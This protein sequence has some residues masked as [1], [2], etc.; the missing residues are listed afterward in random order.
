M[1]R[2]PINRFLKIDFEFA[3]ILRVYFLFT[4]N[5]SIYMFIHYRSSVKNYTLFQTNMGK[6]YNRFQTKTVQKPYQFLSIKKRII[7][8]FQSNSIITRGFPIFPHL[9]NF[10]LYTEDPL[11]VMVI[12]FQIFPASRFLTL[13]KQILYENR[14]LKTIHVNFSLKINSTNS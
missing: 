9:G 2:T 7:V 12:Y 8:F 11:W 6:V 1:I 13:R 4:W 5:Q 3:C 14:F 10:A